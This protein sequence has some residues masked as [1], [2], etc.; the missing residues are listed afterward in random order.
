MALFV[1]RDQT[2]NDRDGCPSNRPPADP[3]HLDSGRSKSSRTLLCFSCV[4]L[5]VDALSG[6]RQRAWKQGIPRLKSAPG[7]DRFVRRPLLASDVERHQLHRVENRIGTSRSKSG[8]IDGD[9]E[10]PEFHEL[11]DNELSS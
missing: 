11:A 2:G 8:E 1:R 3:S 7:R 10:E 6:N 9:V 4:R 5:F